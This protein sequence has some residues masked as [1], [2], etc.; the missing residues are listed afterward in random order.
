MDFIRV[1]SQQSGSSNPYGAYINAAYGSGTVTL[2][3]TLGLSLGEK[4]QFNQNDLFGLQILAKGKVSLADADFYYN[5][6]GDGLFIDNSSGTGDVALSKVNS[7]T[8]RED[9]FEILSAG[10]VS[11]STG[12]GSSNGNGGTAGYG[13]RIDNRLASTPKTVTIT[14]FVGYDNKDLGFW[15]LSDGAITLKSIAAYNNGN[16]SATPDAAGAL[17]NNTSGTTAGVTMTKVVNINVFSDHFTS[18]SMPGLRILSNGAVSLSYVMAY[19]NDVAG[20][21]IKNDYPGK[22]GGVTLTSLNVYSNDDQNLI[23]HTNGAVK[24]TIGSF[25]NVSGTSPNVEIQSLPSTTAV[26]TVTLSKVEIRNSSATGLLVWAK[27]SITLNAV[28][29]DHNDGIGMELA[30]ET[31]SG[32]VSILGTL[33]AN[34]TEYN[35]LEGLIIQTK[36]AIVLTR[37]DVRYNGQTG[38]GSGP[39]IHGALLDN[40]SGFA[41][42]TLTNVNFEQNVYGSGVQ[43]ITL[44]KVIWTGG[45][46]EDNAYNLTAGSP[47]VLINNQPA[48]PDPLTPTKT[49]TITNVS[50]HANNGNGLEVRATGAITLSGVK[51]YNQHDAHSDYGAWLDNSDYSGGVTVTGSGNQFNGQNNLYGLSIDTKGKVSL[52]NLEASGNDQRGIDINNKAGKQDVVITNATINANSSRNGLTIL[53]LGNI[54]L[55]SVTANSNG[56]ST[57]YYNASLVNNDDPLVIKNVTIYKCNFDNGNGNGLFVYTNGN[58]LVNK[59]SS[60]NHGN[61]GADGVVLDNSTGTGYVSIL[62][63]YGANTINNNSEN[64]YISTH[65]T[66]TVTGLEASGSSSSSG[67]IINNSLAPSGNPGVTVSNS[68]FR[69]NSN[70]SGLSISSTGAITLTN[71]TAQSNGYSNVNLDNQYDLT[72]T[73]A[74]TVTRS[75]FSYGVSLG[76]DGLSITASA[77]V[78]LNTVTASGTQTNGVFINAS[79]FSTGTVTISGTNIFSDN[80]FAGLQINA[81][82]AITASNITANGNS[83]EGLYL[84]TDGAI[85]ITNATL[86]NNGQ[87]GIMAEAGGN[88]ILTGVTAILNGSS[89]GFDGMHL[90]TPGHNITITNG[91]S[92]GNGGNGIEALTGTGIVTIKNSLYAGNGYPSN[93]SIAD[94][95]YSGTLILQ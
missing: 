63:T 23:V 89:G 82:G 16:A 12:Y 45:N 86:K 33:G 59:I 71:I 9:G 68:T 27:G 29:A 42:V 49:V 30:N 44:G 80:Q 77:A 17:F 7:Q 50:I 19:S 36:G 3:N 51:I 90:S 5:A 46:V 56:S 43:I 34:V 65:G 20:V 60:S 76:G 13:V 55:T 15:V 6:G 72:H 41:D 91:I 21:I 87:T 93:L 92:F 18:G 37:L 95:V 25:N 11:L 52:S 54:T 2:Q 32:G 88:I 14:N 81:V 24:L 70:G 69:Q 84:D 26:P 64:L 75:N 1:R 79:S 66:V 57:S 61:A 47:A 73:K 35:G 28:T 31:G 62:S 58:I 39:A 53:S 22:T 8:N 38:S 67:A 85:T 4:N 78:V 40:D 74:I 48:I 94:L 83:Y 10:N